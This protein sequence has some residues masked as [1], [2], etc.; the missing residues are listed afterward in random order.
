MS[1]PGI[2]DDVS[3]DILEI[4]MVAARLSQAA[5]DRDVAGYA[6]CLA[7]M[8]RDRLGHEHAATGLAEAAI[9]RLSAMDWTHHKLMNPIIDVDGQRASAWSDVVVDMSRADERGALQHATLGGRYELGFARIGGRWK[10]D[11]RLLHYRYII[12]ASD[13]IEAHTQSHSAQ[14]SHDA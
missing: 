11:L 12:G 13:L 5:D 4:M 6:T 8:V 9:E 7:P 3:A 1:S 14:E 2:G 10:I